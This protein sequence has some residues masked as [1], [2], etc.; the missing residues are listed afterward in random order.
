VTVV[1][2]GVDRTLASHLDRSQLIGRIPWVAHGITSRVPGLGPADGNVGYTPPRNV[3]DAWEMR[4]RWVQAVELDPSRIVRI[5]QVHGAEVAIATAADVAR[6]ARPE[7]EGAPWADA[8]VTATPGLA[9]MTLHA[10]CLPILL[11]DPVHRA[12]AAVHAGWR[13]IVAEIGRTTVERMSTA[14]DSRP[15]ELVA[16]LGP[17]V[18]WENYEVGDEVIEAW[19]R[20]GPE[21]VACRT[22]AGRWRFDVKAAAR[23]TLLAAGLRDDHVETSP[24]CTVRDGDRWFSHRGQGPHT[25]RFAAIIGI[26]D[27]SSA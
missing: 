21:A 26:R 24:I 27:E 23:W 19:T 4:E 3:H 22:V 15:E 20:V 17:A 14:F 2:P 9:L 11:V 10:D 13:G 1:S 7:S 5:R 8:V 18:T 6:G 16:Y 12:V 25:G